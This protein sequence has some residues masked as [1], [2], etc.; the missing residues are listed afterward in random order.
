MIE[1]Q[2]QQHTAIALSSLYSSNIAPENIILQQTRKEFEGDYTI[3]VFPF[4]KL[5]NENPEVSAQK[6]GN[7]LVDNVDDI[8]GYNVIKGFLNLVVNDQYWTRHLA[9]QLPNEQY[10]RL[11][12]KGGAPTVIEFSS[13]NTNKPLHLGHVRNNLL[14]WSVAEILKAAG[15][16]V[17][18][19]NLVN[20]RGIHICKSMLAWEKWY[21]DKTPEST[22]VKG[23]KLVG[24]CYV[25]FDREYKKEVEKLMFGGIDKDRAE[26][27]APLISEARDMLRKWENNDPA[28]R[29]LWSMMN[30]WVYEGFDSTYERLGID[31]DKIYYESDTYLLGKDIVDQGLADGILF[32]K[33]D[34]S[35]WANLTDEG[36]DEKLLLR[37]DGT[38]VYMT[39]DLGTAQLRYDDYHP[40]KLLYVVGNEQNYHFDVLKII[41]K[42]LGRDWANDIVH[43][44]YGMVELPHGKMKSREGTVVDADDLMDQM[45][46]TAEAMARELGKVEGLTD[47]E[48]SYLFEMISL[49][50][51][52]FFILRVD[53]KKNMLFNPEESI[54]FN[55]HTGPFVQY[56]HARIRSLL[57]KAG[58][59]GMQVISEQYMGPVLAKEKEIIKLLHGFPAVV[60]NAASAFS[61]AVIASYVYDLAREYNQ[62]YQEINILRENDKTTAGFRLSLSLATANVIRTAMQF[63]GIDVPDKM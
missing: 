41:L 44:S 14:G 60:G 21:K 10:G 15:H 19:V 25:K 16:K 23:D 43:I 58:E 8:T 45:Y 31:F 22:D 52:K 57:N 13:P 5:T 7:F 47:D 28:V 30:E 20:D 53:P 54:D 48:A 24:D 36:L 1:A 2:I 51:L 4:L 59:R 62:F 49:G 61:P 46:A 63:L 39:Q 34:G 29:E 55:G 50:A 40:D 27:E 17:V 32:K 9:R 37:A 12:D 56:T 38:S 33:D 6:I 18:K 3:N 35:V 26:Q 42:K 11:A